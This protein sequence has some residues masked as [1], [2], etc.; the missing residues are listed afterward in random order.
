MICSV[1]R[2]FFESGSQLGVFDTGMLL[3]LGVCR[4]ECI[5]N[6]DAGEDAS[7]SLA[8]AG[9]CCG[10]EIMHWNDAAYSY[11]IQGRSGTCLRM[12]RRERC[13]TGALEAE[14]SMV[15]LTGGVESGRFVLYMSLNMRAL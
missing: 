13:W 12:P 2:W 15:C 6:Q 3:I 11:L 4:L 14:L 8:P 9:G 10:M 5:A 7:L 1:C